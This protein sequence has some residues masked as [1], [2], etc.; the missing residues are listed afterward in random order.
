[1]ER[2]VAFDPNMVTWNNDIPFRIRRSRLDDITFQ[3]DDALY[4]PRSGIRRRPISQPA[5]VNGSL[6][7]D[8]DVA[9]FRLREEFI[10]NHPIPS[11]IV[12]IRIK[13]AISEKYNNQGILP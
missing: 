12:F 11:P 9:S 2:L 8:D 10:Q 7:E 1:M 5:I 13:L 3:S 4:H 6:L